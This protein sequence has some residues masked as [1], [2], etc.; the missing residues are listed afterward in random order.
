MKLSINIL[1]ICILLV[2]SSATENNEVTGEALSQVKSRFEKVKVYGQAST[3]TEIIATL[4]KDETIDY[5]R[6]TKMNG[7]VW[8]IV[9]VNGRPGYVL[10]SEI[11]DEP[12]LVVRNKK[13]KAKG[14][15]LS[16]TGQ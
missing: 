12:K 6:K 4:E 11:Y 3:S 10:T 13:K 7:G 14:Q 8:S 1:A 16:L 15:V 5:L 2:F 9:K